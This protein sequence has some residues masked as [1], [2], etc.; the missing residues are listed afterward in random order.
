MLSLYH[1]PEHQ[2]LLK[3]SSSTCSGIPVFISGALVFMATAQGIPLDHLALVARG[4][5]VPDSHWMVTIGEAV[6]GWLP[7]PEDCTDGRL[8]HTPSLF[9]KEA[10]L[11]VLELLPYEQTSGLAHI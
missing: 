9:G 2:H 8:K 4:S 3:M 10:Y 11:L 6:L 5:C 7:P 1:A